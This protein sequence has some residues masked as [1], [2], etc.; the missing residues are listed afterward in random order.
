M[1]KSLCAAL[2]LVGLALL[3]SASARACGVQLQSSA[4]LFTPAVS[5]QAVA[6]CPVVVE[7]A[8]VVAPYSVQT[9]A[10]VS[11]Q[12]TVVVQ[13]VRVRAVR[14]RRVVTRTRIR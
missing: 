12:P 2:G 6:P 1:K 11:V 13:R 8:V 5:F 14:G 10:A 9:V 3:S 4:V 7:P